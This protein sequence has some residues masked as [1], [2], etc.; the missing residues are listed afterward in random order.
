MKR[1]T[2]TVGLSAAILATI[3]TGCSKDSPGVQGASPASGAAVVTSSATTSTS[4]LISADPAPK[5]ALA[6]ALLN[7]ITN[8]NSGAAIIDPIIKD[9]NSQQNVLDVKSVG[10]FQEITASDVGL[11]IGN[12]RVDPNAPTMITYTPDEEFCYQY[13]AVSDPRA[14]VR[15]LPHFK[16]IQTV[17]TPSTGSVDVRFDD[18]SVALVRYEAQRLSMTVHMSALISAARTIIETNESVS[19]IVDQ[20]APRF[21]TPASGDLA[22]MIQKN[23]DNTVNLVGSALSDVSVDADFYAGGSLNLRLRR[24][25]GALQATI[26][27]TQKLVSTSVN[28]GPLSINAPFSINDDQ[29]I[30]TRHEAFAVAAGGLLGN[31]DFSGVDNSISMRNVNLGGQQLTLD[32]DSQPSGGAHT[33]TADLTPFSAKVINQSA[34]VLANFVT[35]FHGR[36]AIVDSNHVLGV[37]GTFSADVAA[38]S[39]V[40]VTKQTNLITFTGTQLKLQGTGDLAGLINVTGTACMSTVSGASGPHFPFVQVACTTP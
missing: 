13:A 19:G 28:V 31:F 11:M 30:R 8:I 25:L 14:C 22:I 38:A 7:G 37:N 39:A 1:F 3:A 32:V 34:N 21:H 23:A 12:G 33:I 16:L 36:V 15:T 20:N 35:D 5:A 18:Q 26:N 4:S 27:P 10:I 24:S 9:N 29:G 17:A 40:S 6:T 2:T